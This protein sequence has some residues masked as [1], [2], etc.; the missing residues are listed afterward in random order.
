MLYVM[1]AAYGT[2][3]E[4]RARGGGS[5]RRLLSLFHRVISLSVSCLA[6]LATDFEIAEPDNKSA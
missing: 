6:S 1:H 5:W 3:F 2:A 4:L